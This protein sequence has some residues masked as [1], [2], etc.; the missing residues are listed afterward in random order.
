MVLQYEESSVSIV[1]CR[2]IV[3]PVS[4]WLYCLAKMPIPALGGRSAIYYK[5]DQE[6]ETAYDLSLIIHDKRLQVGTRYE[7]LSHLI[8]PCNHKRSSER[9]R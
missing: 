5:T 1:A 7:S 4:Q 8:R 2:F 6:A 3:L 9:L